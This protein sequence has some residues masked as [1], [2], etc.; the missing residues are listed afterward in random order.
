MTTFVNQH[1]S[2]SRLRLFEE[3]PRAFY[4]RYVEK[5]KDPIPE[6]TDAPDFGK[7]IHAVLEGYYLEDVLLEG[8]SGPIE[9]EKLLG[10]YRTLV[11][12]GYHELAPGL[13]ADLTAYQEGLQILR[14][15]ARSHPFV[16]HM[17]T[18]DVER[19]FRLP[20]GRTSILGYIDRVEK[21][22]DETVRIIDYKTNRRLYRREEL[23]DDLQMSVYG[24][25]ARVLYPW[26]RKVEFEFEMLRFDARQRTVRTLEQLDDVSGYVEDLGGRTETEEKWP[27]KLNPNC[28]YCASRRRCDAYE[29]ALKKGHE[30]TRASK[31]DID[32]LVEE[33]EAVARIAKVAYARQKEIDDVLKARLDR[34]ES[35]EF[36]AGGKRITFVAQS[37]TTYPRSVVDTFVRYGRSAVGIDLSQDAVEKR[38]LRVVPREVEALLDEVV[39]KIPE[40]SVGDAMLLKATVDGLVHKEPTTPKLDVRPVKKR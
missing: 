19:E 37:T 33:R 30:V 26:A 24:W 15:Y 20:V 28:S 17:V 23:E 3:C 5:D 35:G 16:D 27:A 31:D 36:I 10:R 32:G 14:T 40:R 4:F 39:T 18:L 1:L 6:N 34:T 12:D 22:D 38:L 25:A 8:Y 2:V 29:R 11:R 13:V 21:V 9:T 7:V